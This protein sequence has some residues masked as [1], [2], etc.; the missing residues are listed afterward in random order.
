MTAADHSHCSLPPLRLLAHKHAENRSGD[1]SNREQ[2]GS[3]QQHKGGPGGGGSSRED[4]LEKK[5]D[6]VMR[7]LQVCACA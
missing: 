5:L 1:S 6:A 2:G 3:T 4:A 7:E